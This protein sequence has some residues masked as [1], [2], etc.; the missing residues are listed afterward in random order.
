MRFRAPLTLAACFAI[1]TVSC[2]DKPVENAV[3]AAASAAPASSTVAP[4]A[5]APPATSASNGG[6][7]GEGRRRR[8]AGGPAGMMFAAARSLELKDEQKSKVD[9][10]EKTAQESAPDTQRDAIRNASKELQTELVTEVKAGKIENAKLEPKLVAIDKLVTAG[11]DKEAES[12]NALYTALDATQR[13]AVSANVRAKQAARDA[14]MEAKNDAGAAAAAGDAG[15]EP[16]IA[17]REIDR[18]THGLDLDAD[19]QKKVDAIA[20]KEDAAAKPGHPELVEMKKRVESLAAAFEK[21]GFDAKKADPFDA[22][23]VRGPMEQESK[24]VAELLPILKP[25]QREKLATKIEKQE[26]QH[27]GRPRPSGGHRPH[28]EPDV[29]DD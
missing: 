22:K 18:L 17:K 14:K 13:K 3:D 29:D 11:H 19:Q 24:L 7:D 28:M 27:R 5:S 2:K 1:A 21:D 9:A 10:A 20:A 16:G 25:E 23:K 4:L 12:L 26:G 8:G 15:K 6:G